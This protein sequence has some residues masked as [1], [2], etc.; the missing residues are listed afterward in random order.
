M[1]GTILDPRD[2]GAILTSHAD[3]YHSSYKLPVSYWLLVSDLHA[4]DGPPTPRIHIYTE[5][6]APPPT[7]GSPS[8]AP[9]IPLSTLTRSVE[10]LSPHPPHSS[11][12]V[13][14]PEHNCGHDD[15]SR[16]LLPKDDDCE[17]HAAAHGLSATLGLVI[18]G[19]AD[20]IAIGASSLTGNSKLSMVVFIAVIVHK[21][22]FIRPLFA[23]LTPKAPRRS[24]SR[25]PSSPSTSPRPRCA[26]AS[27][28][29]RPPRPS[30]RSRRT[31]SSR[32][33]V[34]RRAGRG[35]TALDGGPVSSS[36][37]R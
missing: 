34:A 21:G 24:A 12:L 2:V 27:L 25:P 30:A 6:P 35:N 26:A 10:N 22:E 23:L 19:A 18:H 11:D 4:L 14:D 37:S 9:V 8:P 29:F 36:Y 7:P 20:G 13:D 15:A 16:Q 32:R 17:T 3:H 33:L 1:A 28:S 31:L 5:H